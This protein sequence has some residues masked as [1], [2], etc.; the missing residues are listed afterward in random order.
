MTFPWERPASP[1]H[2]ENG[3]THSRGRSMIGTHVR[4]LALEGA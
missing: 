3:T 4:A 1:K 2:H